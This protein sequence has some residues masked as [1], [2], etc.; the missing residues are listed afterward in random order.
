MCTLGESFLSL[1]PS[2]K[3]LMMAYSYHPDPQLNLRW[4]SHQL[5]TVDSITCIHK[6]RKKEERKKS[7]TSLNRWSIN[8]KWSVKR[9]HLLPVRPTGFV[10]FWHQFGLS[11]WVT[12]DHNGSTAWLQQANKTIVSFPAQFM[13]TELRYRSDFTI[14]VHK[15]ILRARNS[16]LLQ[17]PA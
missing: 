6:C 11:L 8:I 14:L 5:D 15:G 3:F 1:Q 16:L 7:F 13:D 4:W 2:S 17:F 12:Q 9:R 10:E